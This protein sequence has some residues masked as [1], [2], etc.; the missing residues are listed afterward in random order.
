MV[1][2]LAAHP[3]GLKRVLAQIVE[4]ARASGSKGKAKMNDNVF[5]FPDIKADRETFA[6]LL[7]GTMKCL[8]VVASS[9]KTMRDLAVCDETIA[10]V[11]RHAATCCR[12][13]RIIPIR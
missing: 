13:R 11:L 6:E 8:P 4:Q 12:A 3:N 7:N 10:K 9:I 5:R 1:R 2:S